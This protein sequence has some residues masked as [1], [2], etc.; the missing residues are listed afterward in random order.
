VATGP[1]RGKLSKMVF[2]ATNDRENPALRLECEAEILSAL[3]CDPERADL[4][5]IKRNQ[6]KIEQSVK[7]TRGNGGPL[8]P[9]VAF[10]TNPQ[11]TAELR[12]NEPGESYDLLVAA[13][14]PWPNGTLRATVQIETGVE[15]VPLESV[16]VLA[17]VAPRL[18][19]VPARFTLR[20][21]Q[22]GDLRL[23]A[24]LAWDDEQPGNATGATVNDPNLVVRI[25]QQRDQQ[26]VVLNVP[27]DYNP[28]PNKNVQVTVKT[29]DAAVPLLQ[30]PVTAMVT[31]SGGAPPAPA[32]GP[33]RPG[34]SPAAPRARAPVPPATKPPAPTPAGGA[35]SK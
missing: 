33:K 28:Q 14:P 10:T 30:I 9:R 8:K 21:E 13:Q 7:I 31:P 16:V 34:A 1:L 12:E 17:S 20:P 22:K 26:V 35:Q 18:Q 19:A 4:G 23:V 15:Q 11:V 29:D 6:G 5:R 32:A 3:K 2:V 24:R 27:T 25:E